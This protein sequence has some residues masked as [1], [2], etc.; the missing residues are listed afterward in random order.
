MIWPDRLSCLAALLFASGAAHGSDTE[1]FGHLRERATLI[2][3]SLWGTDSKGEDW[4]LTHRYHVGASVAGQNVT[5]LVEVTGAFQHGAKGGDSPVEENRLDINRAW[6]EIPFADKA[7]R[8]RIG[9]DEWKLGSQ[10]LV[11]WRDGTNVHRRFNGTRLTATGNSYDIQLLA[12]FEAENDPGILDDSL[13][14][15]RALWGIYSTFDAPLGL[16]GKVDLYYLGFDSDR[17][18]NQTLAGQERRHSF[19]IRLAGED[20]DWDWD[21]EGVW[22]TGHFQP[23]GPRQK[24]QAW[25][26][27]GIAGYTFAD[28]PLS[29]RLAL[30]AN[31]ASGDR[32]PTD[33]TFGAFNALFPRGSYFSDLA[34]LGPRNFY[35]FNPYLTLNLTEELKVTADMNMFWRYAR[36]DGVYSPSGSLVFEGDTNAPRHVDTS[37]SFNLEYQPRNGLFLGAIYTRAAPKAFVKAQ[38]T[39]ARTTHFVELTLRFDF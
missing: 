36:A 26:L 30:S 1:F 35:N 27:A 16:S 9:R 29:P 3:N 24:I 13:I 25:T 4:F 32:N 19:G 12:G 5:A 33:R 14:N 38:N 18:I 10:R 15:N 11:G 17:G 7:L 20:D 21:L 22:Q 23:D 31:V 8:L 6:I 34:H 37:T 28:L 39:D 2:D